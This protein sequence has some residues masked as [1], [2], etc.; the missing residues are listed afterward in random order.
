[1]G[2]QTSGAAKGD[3]AMKLLGIM[4]VGLLVFA[5]TA[6]QEV[7]ADQADEARKTG[8]NYYNGTGV[9]QDYQEAMNWFIKSAN[10]GNSIAQYNIGL[11][12][13]NGDG[14][15]KNY[16]E[17]LKWYRKA[18]E[19][20]DADAQYSLGQMYYNGNGVTQS[21]SQALK[22]YRKAADK[23]HADA[24]SE[25]GSMYRD[26]DGVTLNYAEALKWYRKAVDQGNAEA[27][28]CMGDMYANGHG[29]TEDYSKARR[30]YRKAADQGLAAAQF[31]LGQIY[32]GDGDNSEA[33]RWYRKAADQGNA[34]AQ[35][36][37]GDLYS[38]GHGV[39]KD[40]AEALRWYHK[41]ADQGY[42]G[43]ND[44]ILGITA[45]QKYEK[46]EGVV[47]KPTAHA[48]LSLQDTGHAWKEASMSARTALCKTMTYG[49]GLTNDYKYWL[50]KID[51]VYDSSETLWLPIYLAV[52]TI[53][54]TRSIN[55]GIAE[56]QKYLGR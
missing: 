23:G 28:Y 36:A 42:E 12:Y 34:S 52:K 44:K 14:V 18:A 21:Y 24:Q 41:A 11:M 51:N 47:Q 33:L 2:F 10:Q 29:V 45:R 53:E 1:M 48:A 16:E 26:G 20:G 39:T 32:Y 31:E 46:G 6:L 8:L 37:L 54:T 27:Q 35:C 25:I 30:W 15:T 50:D 56:K 40:Y 17:A 4:M 9:K 19:R 55:E 7:G 13:F 5:F 43:A 38:W 3:F 49:N 22:W